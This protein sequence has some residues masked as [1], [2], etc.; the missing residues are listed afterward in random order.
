MIKVLLATV[1]YIIVLFI[2]SPTI[3]HLFTPLD[4][5]D[6][7]YKIMLEIISQIMVIS[8]I[9]YFISEFFILK[10]NHLLNIKNNKLLNKAREVISAV[11]IVGLQTHL[12]SKLEYITQKHPFRYLKLN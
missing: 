8:V 2:V 7:N 12:T 11:I 1:M 5:N 6:S 9:W 3:D 10:I 4:E